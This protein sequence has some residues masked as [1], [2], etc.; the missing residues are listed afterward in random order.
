MR[1]IHP[2]GRGHWVP[3]LPLLLSPPLPATGQ[4][5][6]A[7]WLLVSFSSLRLRSRLLLSGSSDV[8]CAYLILHSSHFLWVAPR[9]RTVLG[10]LLIPSSSCKCRLVCP[11]I[12]TNHCCI[13]IRF[14]H[15]NEFI[16]CIPR[17]FIDLHYHLVCLWIFLIFCCPATRLI[18]SHCHLVC[19]WISTKCRCLPRTITD[20]AS[21]PSFLVALH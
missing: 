18:S 9:I 4:A 17:R 8:S 20:P 11:Q 19:P 3:P 7:V 13:L 14:I 5:L 2:K 10:L 15:L 12:S 21:L 1:R 6:P 16:C